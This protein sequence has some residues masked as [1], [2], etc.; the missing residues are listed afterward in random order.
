MLFPTSFLSSLASHKIKKQFEI[1]KISNWYFLRVQMMVMMK[2]CISHE[3]ARNSLN[4]PEGR[5]I[6]FVPLQVK[7]NLSSW[8]MMRVFMQRYFESDNIA[9][10]EVAIAGILVIEVVPMALFIWCAIYKWKA[11]LFYVTFLLALN[12]IY[13]T[14]PIY[15]AVLI[16]EQQVEQRNTLMDQTFTMHFRAGLVGL[17]HGGGAGNNDT[18]SSKLDEGGDAAAAG[19][20]DD[21]HAD[22][23]RLELVIRTSEYLAKREKIMKVLMIPNENIFLAPPVVHRRRHLG[24]DRAAGGLESSD[25]G[26]LM[27]MIRMIYDHSYSLSAA[28]G[29]RTRIRRRKLEIACRIYSLESTC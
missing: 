28:T 23:E 4:A 9:R 29:T 25:R 21:Y 17:R 14:A 2:D 11:E 12:T 1:A 22:R 26:S 7:N 8:L 10:S 16:N 15:S 27:N 18:T 19:A 3:E 20:I 24:W 13:I 5:G 6:P